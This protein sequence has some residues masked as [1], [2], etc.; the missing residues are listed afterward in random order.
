M[1]FTNGVSASKIIALI[2]NLAVVIYLLLAKRLFGLHGGH[3]AEQARR[4]RSS[5]WGAV[6]Q[7]DA[8]RPRLTV[9]FRPVT[10]RVACD[11]GRARALPSSR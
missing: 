10:R 11:A 4:E 5:G 9:T 8:R 2:I 6:E 3:L 1:S 7:G